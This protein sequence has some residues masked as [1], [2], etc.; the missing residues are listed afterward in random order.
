MKP[1]FVFTFEKSKAFGGFGDFVGR[2]QTLEDVQK[3]LKSEIRKSNGIIT[4]WEELQ[5]T[6]V[7]SS[8]VRIIFSGDCVLS[9]LGMFSEDEF[10]VP[11]SSIRNR[12]STRVKK[13][14][15]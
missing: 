5:I 2:F 14:L 15:L 4:G 13:A 1:Y 6:E 7:N 8:N 3:F 9:Y 10:L 12:F 11:D